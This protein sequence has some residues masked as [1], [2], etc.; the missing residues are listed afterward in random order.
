[1]KPEENDFLTIQIPRFKQYSVPEESTLE[2]KIERLQREVDSFL[3]EFDPNSYEHII[4]LFAYQRI[5]SGFKDS[6]RLR[7][8]PQEIQVGSVVKSLSSESLESCYVAFGLNPY[9]DRFE[10]I[11]EI[12]E[13]NELTSEEVID[14]AV[15]VMLIDEG[16]A[17]L[18]CYVRDEEALIQES[19]DEHETYY[20][21]HNYFVWNFMYDEYDRLYNF[22]S[23]YDEDVCSNEVSL[24]EWISTFDK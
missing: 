21:L 17:S 14:S 15:Y 11:Y 4:R 10:V 1:M 16:F 19:R 20:R 12:W 23:K 7:M 18:S 3:I 6:T 9:V 5:L 13:N 22:D 8:N 24:A 2:E